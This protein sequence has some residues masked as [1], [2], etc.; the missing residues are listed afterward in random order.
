[1][2]IRLSDI[3]DLTVM[4]VMFDN[5]WHAS[6]IPVGLIDS[7]G[8]V[9]IATGWQKLCTEYH[10]KHPE[11]K[12][13]CILNQLDSFRAGI[14]DRPP[15]SPREFICNSGLLDITLPIQCGGEYI[16]LLFLGQFLDRP[17]DRE[18]SRRFAAQ[19][20]FEPDEYLALL[21]EVPVIPRQKIDHFLAFYEALVKVLSEAGLRKLREEQARQSL[22]QSEQALRESEERFRSIVQ[23]IPLGIHMYHCEA[24]G[25][26]VFAGY[27]P[28]AD[29][30][31][32]VDNSRFLGKELLEAFPALAG[33]E[34][35]ERYQ[36]VCVSGES[37]QAE[38]ISYANGGIAGVF[39]VHAFRTGPNRIA[40]IF[41]DISERR[42][43]LEVIRASEATL[44]SILTAAPLS[45]GLGHG[46]VLI[47]VNRWMLDML[48]YAEEALVGRSARVLYESDVEFERVGE[49]R[50]ATVNRGRMGEVETRW[51]RF[52]GTFIDVLLRFVRI[53]P[54][55]PAEQVIFTALDITKAKRAAREL[56]DREERIRLLL[57]SS[58]EGV[59]G[60]DNHG[61]CIFANQMCL[62]LLGF[63]TETELLGQRTHE[64]MHHSHKD[65][66]PYTEQA[67]PICRSFRKG[68][69]VHK[70]EELFWRADGH[71]FPV[72]YW[73]HP[74]IKEGKVV[75]AVVNFIDITERL[76]A[77]QR[78]KNAL[79][80]TQQAREQ[81]NAILSSMA[82]ALVVIDPAGRITMLNEAAIE[83]LGGDF[84][85]IV[86]T[87]IRE[88]FPD[89]HFLSRV[90]QTIAGS[91]ISTVFDMTP[92][93]DCSGRERILQARLTKI[94]SEEH[95]L[96]GAVALL[97]D[98]T[99]EREIERLK[100]D[101]I[102]T[103]AHELRTPITAIFGYAEFM[104]D[105]LP[106]L[107]TGQLQEYLGVIC[108]RSEALTQIVEEMLDLSRMQ[109]GQVIRLDLKPGDLGSLARDV[110]SQYQ[111]AKYDHDF[112]LEVADPLPSIEFDAAKLRQVFD[113][114][115]SNAFKF[116]PPRS[117]IRIAVVSQDHELLASVTDQGVGMTPEQ[118]ERIFDKFYRAD[119]SATAVS[120]LGLGMSLVKGIIEGHGGRIWVTSALGSGTTVSFSLPVAK[121]TEG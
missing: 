88:K 70:L 73:A 82:D 16:G 3:L 7:R 87:S 39:E 28:A 29:S 117:E 101:F 119:A 52:D 118:V 111:M 91:D 18:T 108:K 32:K 54:D 36:H 20:G 114:L 93:R 99:R 113:N 120:G 62:E 10:R 58:G 19:C 42:Q 102:S 26:L 103:A 106:G 80:Q 2:D 107:S 11:L 35:P 38:Q 50:A 75:G 5:L 94:A 67:C 14:P 81:L 22:A 100:D 43:I 6:G 92:S 8:E 51:R 27:N 121:G 37:W 105:Q 31:L 98:V 60:V 47:W 74:V 45:I 71:G 25:R 48:G 96:S 84:D 33:T 17:P 41:M 53:D 97:R 12:S 68:D 21:D 78:L 63:N 1:L 95:H 76:Q 55:D 115:L 15:Q 30:V 90:D 49:V 23:E 40:S 24:D 56:A 46:R 44:R 112:I 13:H 59:F 57:N 65:G 77:E 69:S 116:S 34:V 72:E 64:I 79:S 104:F 86:G 61:R 66:T 109:A 110:V 4:Q 89:P 9:L 85:Q 83:L